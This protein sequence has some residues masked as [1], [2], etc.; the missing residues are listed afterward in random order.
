[1]AKMTIRHPMRQH[2]KS[3][4]PYMNVTR[5]DEPVS[6]DPMFSN[7]R[8]IYYSYTAAQI[9]YETKSHSIIVYGI[10]S[11]GE[12]P[13]VYKDFIREHVPP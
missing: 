7:C 9:F 3:R 4:F 8:S 13:K 6:T 11:K 1:M 2:V 12:F 5:I 10:K